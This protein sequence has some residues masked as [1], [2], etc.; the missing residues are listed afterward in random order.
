MSSPFQLPERPTSIA[1]LGV[2]FWD[3]ATGAY[4]SNGLK[5]TAYPGDARLASTQAS[6][7]RSGTYVLHH[8]WGLR[9]FEMG[10]CNPQFT[11]TSPPR[12]PFTVEVRDEKR[13]F[14]PVKFE[15][16]LPF[17]GLFRWQA[18][19]ER[20]P[21]DP[22]PNSASVPLYSST[23]RPAPAGMAV[24][25]AEIYE[26]PSQEINGVRVNQPAAWAMLEARY[27]GRLL[28][29]GIADEQGRIALI[30]PY[31][32]PHDSV[33]S[34]SISPAGVFAAGLP[35]LE[36][37]WTIQLQARYE[38]IVLSS[39]LSPL[40]PLEFSSNTD[41]SIPNLRNIL[42]QSPVSLFL[43]E[44]QTE[45]L[46]DVTLMYGSKVFVPTT[47]SPLGPVPLSVLFISPAG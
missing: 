24:L 7:N 21:L 18:S 3:V 10:L 16:D 37:E 33:G 20:A 41:T 44:A 47:V 8:A 28:S 32:P 11:E 2:R 43:D 13:F 9:E 39:P 19:Q 31:P 45:P 36:Q 35:F 29:R 23:L 38:P 25:R 4:V 22:P 42:A 30:F 6:L 14:L 5:V 46:T 15:A 40:S 1:P 17:A 34:G 27:G 12:R 26:T